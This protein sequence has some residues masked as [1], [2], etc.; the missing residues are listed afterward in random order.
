MGI[1]YG[2]AYTRFYRLRAYYAGRK[3]EGKAFFDDPTA[4]IPT[5]TS[6]AKKLAQKVEANEDTKLD[7]I[8]QAVESEDD[9]F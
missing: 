8:P 3:K 4:L 9:M 1:T 7:E 2:A 5:G 6:A